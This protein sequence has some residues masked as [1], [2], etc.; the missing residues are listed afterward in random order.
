LFSQ[1]AA[2]I[3][4]QLGFGTNVAGNVPAKLRGAGA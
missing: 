3:A 4:E 2:S 1:L